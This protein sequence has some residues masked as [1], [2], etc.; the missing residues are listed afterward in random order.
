M[1]KK[2]DPEYDNRVGPERFETKTKPKYVALKL[3]ALL[4]CSFMGLWSA[5]QFLAYTFGYQDALGTNIEHIYIPWA[6]IEWELNWHEQYPE[7]FEQAEYIVMGGVFAGFLIII[8][9]TLIAEGKLK[10]SKYLHG[11]ARWSN[12]KDIIDAGLIQVKK[13]LSGTLKYEK[14]DIH[15]PVVYVGAFRDKHNKFHYLTHSG[16]E[17]ILCFAPTRSGKGVGLVVPTMLSW[18]HSV[19]VND[20]KGELWALTA[21]YRQKVLGGKCI[22]LEFAAQGSAHWNPLDEIRVG[23]EYEIGDVQNLAQMIVDP[24][25]KGLDGHDG[26]WKKTAFALYT[27]LILFVI[28]KAKEVQNKPD[29]T[30]EDM[31]YSKANL[32]TIDYLLANSQEIKSLWNEMASHENETIRAA[33]KDMIDRPDDE[34]GSVLSTVKSNLSLYRDPIV[35]ENVSYSD[36]SIRDLMNC[37]MPVS[38]YLISQ[39]SDKGRIRPILRIFI[40]MCMRLLVNKMKFDKGKTVKIYTHRLLMMMDEFPALGKMEIVQESLAFVAGYGIKC[41]LITQDLGQL[42]SAYGKDESVSS[43][44]HIQNCFPAIKE[45]TCEYISKMTGETT[46]VRE[47]KTRNGSGLKASYSYSVQE[48]QRRLLTPGEVKSLPGAVKTPDGMIKKAGKMLIFSAGHPPI[49]G[50]QPLY[51]KDP[52]FSE[53]SAIDA[54]KKSDVITDIDRVFR[55]EDGKP[56]IAPK[57]KVSEEELLNSLNNKA[58]QPEKSDESNNSGVV[59]SE[60]KQT[61]RHDDSSTLT[62]SNNGVPNV[63]EAEKKEKSRCIK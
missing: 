43:N 54:P 10:G 48:T 9:G 18:G 21:G 42:Y 6:M 40:C 25:G 34:A 47:V 1:S 59:V 2:I 62:T 22:R 56:T 28:Y 53:R 46:V 51:F 44:C 4:F 60:Q 38:L 8:I 20:I 37:K 3:F 31:K 24:D 63:S 45:D 11:S 15:D 13:G 26:H 39:P 49:F 50:E 52:V 5:T 57:S 61:I 14:P 36:F 30:P 17:H 19:V 41:Y 23:T 55:D 12:E 27:G 29:P 35:A 32:A 58:K 33:G 16:P 7:V